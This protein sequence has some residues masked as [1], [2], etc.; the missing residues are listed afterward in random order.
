MGC[1]ASFTQ[2]C[3]IAFGLGGSGYYQ[4]HYCEWKMPL[5]CTNIYGN[6]GGDWVDSLAVRLGVDGNI[7]ADPAF[8]NIDFEPYDLSLC[9]Y[10]PC[11]PGNHPDGYACGLI[12]ALGEG[13]VCDPT[14]VRPSTWGAIKA[15]YR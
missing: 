7:C 8:C 15:L 13:C 5:R 4:P 1:G 2:N 12:G 6:Q 9:D 3:I 11:L 14:S 10:S